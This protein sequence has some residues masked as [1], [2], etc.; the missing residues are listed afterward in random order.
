MVSDLNTFAQKGCKIAA[1]FFSLIH[2]VSIFFAP[3]FRSPIS[4]C[5]KSDS[6]GRVLKQLGVHT[7]IQFP[8][9]GLFL[10]FLLVP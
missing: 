5:D 9:V 8:A 1:D 7:I 3:T 6:D 2:S 4:K 10:R